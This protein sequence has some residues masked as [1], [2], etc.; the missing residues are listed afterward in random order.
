MYDPRHHY[1]D[2]TNIIP[3]NTPSVP[4]VIPPTYGL[5]GVG[6]ETVTISS[7]DWV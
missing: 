2:G 1:F 7:S 4:I 5:K 6:F 3:L